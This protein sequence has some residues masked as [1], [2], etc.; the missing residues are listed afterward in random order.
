MPVALS[1]NERE[2]IGVITASSLTLVKPPASLML[3]GL[4]DRIREMRIL[5]RR[6]AVH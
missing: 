6:T 3:R 2:F 1:S 4:L 5:V